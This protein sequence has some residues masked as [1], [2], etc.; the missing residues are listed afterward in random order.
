MDTMKT[1]TKRSKNVL[2]SAQIVFLYKVVRVEQVSTSA[3]KSE[4]ASLVVLTVK[5]VIQKAA[6]V[7]QF[8]IFGYLMLKKRVVFL[9]RVIMKLHKSNVRSVHKVVLNVFLKETVA[10]VKQSIHFKVVL[11]KK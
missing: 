11:A 10:F 2:M 4:N 5:H 1:T 7:A 9:K 3:N 6:Q 8:K